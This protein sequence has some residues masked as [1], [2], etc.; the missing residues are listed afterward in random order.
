MSYFESRLRINFED[1]EK[2]KQTITFCEQLGIKN[3]ILEPKVNSDNINYGLIQKLKAFSK[4]NIYFRFNLAPRTLDEFK[5]LLKNY[6]SFPHILS[7][8]TPD[9]EI[10]V[11]A[12]KDS[13]VDILS[14]SSQDIIKTISPGVVSLVK[15]NNSFLELSLAP[16]MRNNK[17]IQSKNFRNLYRFT[18]LILNLKPKYIISGNF[19]ELYSL[20]NPRNLLSVC[21]TLLGMPLIDAKKGFKDNVLRLLNRVNLRNDKTIITNGV[22]IIKGGDVR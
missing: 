8:E 6:N 2:V 11:Y 21:H 16:I 5:S 13:R 12:A 9:K 4:V 15:Q 22:K 10:Q 19:D 14:F 18:K 20:R 1:F 7:V 17:A 3:L